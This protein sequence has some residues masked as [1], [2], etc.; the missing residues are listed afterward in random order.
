VPAVVSAA[1]PLWPIA[2]LFVASLLAVSNVIP[3]SSTSVA[4]ASGYLTIR[5]DKFQ[6]I[7]LE[8][9]NI[10]G[11]AVTP[12]TTWT[13]A[14][15]NVSPCGLSV[16]IKIYAYNGVII[17]TAVTDPNMAGYKSFFYAWRLPCDFPMGIGENYTIEASMVVAGAEIKGQATIFISAPMGA[18]TE[19][20]AVTTDKAR[21]AP[22]EIVNIK[23]LFQSGALSI[24][25]GAGTAFVDIAVDVTQPPYPPYRVIF[26]TQLNNLTATVFSSA[27]CPMVDYPSGEDYPLPSVYFSAS[28]KLLQDASEAY[29][30]HTA[31]TGFR[32][33]W[34]QIGINGGN[35][36]VFFT[37]GQ[38][39]YTATMLGMSTTQRSIS[40]I[41]ASASSYMTSTATETLVL[42]SVFTTTVPEFRGTALTALVALTVAMALVGW[43]F[44]KRKR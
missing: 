30:V 38:W 2:L 41:P 42:T 9:V 18:T 43:S 26:E 37:V 44:R 16:T 15:A 17:H 13:Y 5:T 33:A 39:N 12:S 21:Y 20:L 11:S 35:G 25:G 19:A 22:G 36:E 8:T 3:V 7:P 14:C 24:G 1:R 32:D 10:W 40:F 27:N 6:Y 34:G 23:G 29:A 31:A 28:F 4:E